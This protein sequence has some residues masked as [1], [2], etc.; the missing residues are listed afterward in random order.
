MLTVEPDQGTTYGDPLQIVQDAGL[1][2]T[3]NLT[4]I[5]LGYK[6][7][8]WYADN[9]GDANTQQDAYLVGCVRWALDTLGD[10]NNWNYL[11]GFSKSGFGG[12]ILFLRHPQIFKATATWDFP[13]NFAYDAYGSDG[14]DSWGS[15]TNFDTNYALTASH[16]SA[17]RDAPEFDIT[18]N[19]RIWIGGY[20]AFQGDVDSYHTELT[21]AGIQHTYSWQES[22]THAWHE[23][24]VSDALSHIVAT[25]PNVTT[26]KASIS[27]SGQIT[28]T[29]TGAV[30]VSKA[31]TS[32]SGKVGAG[33]G[34]YG[35]T[36]YITT[37]VTRISTSGSD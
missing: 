11:I 6:I 15:Q 35:K 37:Y 13:W 1:H 23:D 16:I 5:E 24:W 36:T 18:T 25:G 22:E 19:N 30:S 12:Q 28:I 4:C 7:D 2:N 14:E 21:S 34:T 8:P 3:Y 10:G 32:A 31:I 26:K 9:D 29:G 17:W 27:S 33:D 20:A